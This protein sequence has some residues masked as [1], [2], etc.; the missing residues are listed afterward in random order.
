MTAHHRAPATRLSPD[1]AGFRS[2]GG[3]GAIPVR[4]GSSRP[5]VH[6]VT[7]EEELVER[8]VNKADRLV[9]MRSLFGAVNASELRHVAVTEDVFAALVG[10]LSH[11]HPQVRW[12]CIQMLD[13][14]PDPRA[15]EA[16]VPLLDD[17]V[18]RVRRNAAHALGCEVCK[19]DWSGHLETSAIERL[20]E[21][22]SHDPSTKVRD[23]AARALSC[24]G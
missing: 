14:C 7:P 22:A 3:D 24:P 4:G 23:E 9:V 17:P 10:G 19:P 18:P 15:V 5:T 13:H 12:W 16:I 21:M 20:T 11:D 2:P 1:P 8:L 6:R